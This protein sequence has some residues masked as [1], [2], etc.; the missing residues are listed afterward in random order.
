MSQI[1]LTAAHTLSKMIDARTAGWIRWSSGDG[2]WRWTD[3]DEDYDGRYIELDGRLRDHV[4]V[5]EP[6]RDKHVGPQL[7]GFCRDVTV[8]VVLPN[9]IDMGDLRSAI[10]VL[11]VIDAIPMDTNNS[12]K[13]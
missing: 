1:E 4:P 6:M 11:E 13:D 10:E 3:P 8:S 12:T 9:M 7:L 5:A 2:H